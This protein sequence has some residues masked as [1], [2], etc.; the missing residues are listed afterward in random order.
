M[1][2]DLH[3]VLGE[4]TERR[5]NHRDMKVATMTVV[6]FFSDSGVG[7]WARDRTHALAVK[8]PSRVIVLDGTQDHA[9]QVVGSS[10]DAHADCVKTRGDWIELGVRDS[11]PE[12][13]RSAVSTL[14]LPEAPVVLIWVAAGIGEDPRFATLSERM[15]TVVYNS[16]VL[17]S[18]DQALR[19]LMTFVKAHPNVAICDLA[20][21]RLAPWQESIALFFDGKDVIRELF[22]LRRVEITCGSDSEAY[23][24]LG[25]LAS[26]L[27]WTPC[28]PNAFCNRFGVQ[29]D[30]SI[31][32]EGRARRIRRVALKS[33]GT[34]FVAEVDDD[35]A[36]AIIL[37]VSGEKEHARRA[38]P[39][40]NVDIATLVERAILTGQDRVFVESLMA[41]GDLLQR[42]KVNA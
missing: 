27:E 40:N 15:R 36:E 4:I 39:I 5:R 6:V 38:R 24:L 30:F 23:Y 32:R 25:W 13:L 12:A 35:K 8:H 42:R 2:I 9:M 29:I 10:C 1:S 18:D 34:E 22:D 20:Y 17:D 16:S 7:D 14:S 37:T 21:L 3:S 19:E 11:G 31:Q 41:A 33:S 28:S 26:R